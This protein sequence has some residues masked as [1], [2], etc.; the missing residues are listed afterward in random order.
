V[1]TA[2]QKLTVAIVIGLLV[3]TEGVAFSD[4]GS[5]TLFPGGIRLGEIPS[6]NTLPIITPTYHQTSDILYG[7]LNAS[8]LPLLIAN[9]GVVLT[10]GSSFGNY[11]KVWNPVWS[12][13]FGVKT[14]LDFNTQT[15]AVNFNYNVPYS[16]RI[17]MPD[18]INANRTV[19]LTPT[20]NWDLNN[21]SIQGSE[22]LK[23][24]T[25]QTVEFNAPLDGMDWF[26]VN[27]TFTP[28]K[29]SWAPSGY[30]GQV[31]IGGQAPVVPGV[32]S[33]AASL[34]IFTIP[35]ALPFPAP[36]AVDIGPIELDIT[37]FGQG[38]LNSGGSILDT[39]SNPGNGYALLTNSGGSITSAWNA[40]TDLITLAGT[41]VS[42]F[43]ASNPYSEAI[44]NA[45]LTASGVLGLDLSLNVNIN[46]IDSLLIKIID[47]ADIR[48]NWNNSLW[49][50]L[51]SVDLVNHQFD[52]YINY[53][54]LPVS[55]YFYTINGALDA[56]Y[57]VGFRDGSRNL[58]DTN[59]L[60]NIPIGMRTGDWT[61]GRLDF[62][63]VDTVRVINPQ[64]GLVLERIPYIPGEL[65]AVASGI[66]PAGT[67]LSPGESLNFSEID[68]STPVPE[69]STLLLLGAGLGGLA[70]LR[71]KA[72]K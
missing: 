31:V 14:N 10:D 32:S 23:W 63:F 47:E 37:T 30:D 24:G 56:S 13:E 16:M 25:A 45:I 44:G 50:G 26:T 70:L 35:P 1:I 9:S 40:T 46:R 42:E 58:L 28:D 61:S 64:S 60:I 3:L 65:T 53:E 5:T 7:S 43:G 41:V 34:P 4:I 38:N 12:G 66:A 27:S 8:S 11:E 6:G 71:R 59:G 17:D 29:L 21:A 72:K 67:L 48:V 15:S 49:V 18:S 54:I 69:P 2:R 36:Y 57:D 62:S 51:D 55:E 33:S 22:A 68:P 52:T 19:S 39:T 20:I